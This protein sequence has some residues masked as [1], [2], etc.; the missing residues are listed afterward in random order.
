MPVLIKP[1]PSRSRALFLVEA[2]V[3]EPSI[4]KIPTGKALR[5]A[6]TVRYDLCSWKNSFGSSLMWIPL[7][8]WSTSSWSR[9]SNSGGTSAAPWWVYASAA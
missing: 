2:P 5:F 4:G 3:K 1:A 8:C 6:L 7:L 9:A